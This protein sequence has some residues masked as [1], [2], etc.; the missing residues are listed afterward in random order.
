MK[1]TFLFT[2]FL[3]LAGC[4]GGTTPNAGIGWSNAWAP[5]AAAALWIIGVTW[6]LFGATIVGVAVLQGTVVGA[7][8]PKGKQP[9]PNE[10]N[11]LLIVS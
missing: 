10:C 8:L 5:Y 1:P 3:L 4:I 2:P 7:A 11:V 6:E 9:D